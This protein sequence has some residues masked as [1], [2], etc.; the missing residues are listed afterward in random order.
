MQNDID[1]ADHRAE[2]RF[3]IQV[4]RNLNRNFAA[5][6]VHGMLG[7]TGFRLLNA[8]TF[9]PAYIMLL[10]GG[11]NLAVGFSSALQ[12]FG[13]MLTPMIGANLIEHRKQVLPVAFST[14]WGMR[15]MV[16]AIALSGL[17]LP[18]HLALWAIMLFLAV[19]G[20]FQ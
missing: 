20:L 15:S 2:R 10:S 18:P 9:L 11:S 14:G 5:H 13:M 1:R 8:P 16:L 19:F 12:S 4:Q 6:L 7:Q 17:I 3:Q